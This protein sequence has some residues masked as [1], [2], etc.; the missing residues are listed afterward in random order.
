MFFWAAL[1]V[2][3][4]VAQ[5]D[6]NTENSTSSNAVLDIKLARSNAMSV[7]YASW[8]SNTWVKIRQ[9]FEKAPALMNERAGFSGWLHR[10]C[11]ENNHTAAQWMLSHGADVNMP[12]IAGRTPLFFVQDLKMAQLLLSHG[13]D[14]DSENV[15]GSTALYAVLAYPLYFHPEKGDAQRVESE[16]IALLLVEHGADMNVEDKD[17]NTIF[18]ALAQGKHYQWLG[19]Y[20][21]KGIGTKAKN[22]SGVGIWVAPLS[23]GEDSTLD[24]LEQNGVT[25]EP[26]DR[27]LVRYVVACGN[28]R[29]M[30]KLQ[31]KDFDIN[32]ADSKT[33]L[34]LLENEIVKCNNTNAFNMLLECGAQI[35]NAS[36]VY[37][38]T[39]LLY[40]AVENIEIMRY[41]L[42][43]GA[44]VDGKNYK[45]VMPLFPAVLRSSPEA[46]GLLLEHG[47]EM[48]HELVTDYDTLCWVG[49]Q[50]E[51][52]DRFVRLHN[53]TPLILAVCNGRKKVVEILLDHGVDV[54]L[55]TQ[56]GYTALTVAEKLHKRDIA[57]LLRRKGGVE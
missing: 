1:L 32:K 37:R 25:Y 55:R 14:V 49:W 34:T 24:W 45:G 27:A 33:G 47:T 35:D 10:A 2:Q 43:W 21:R 4:I 54:N 36:K 11:Q 56:E 48:N 52:N 12:D 3:M 19:K 30:K 16:R 6:L 50:D 44:D 8:D 57:D 46:V 38:G 15:A 9:Q 29:M 22:K 7:L 41:L 40:S 17:G 26:N 51:T 5:S 42:S 31:K 39:P 13:A 18:H 20:L 28:T 53:V 23:R